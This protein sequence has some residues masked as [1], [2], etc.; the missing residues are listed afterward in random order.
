MKLR[1]TNQWSHT[2]VY[3]LSQKDQDD[4]DMVC[5]GWLIYKDDYAD[6]EDL[7]YATPEIEEM[8]NCLDVDN[9]NP[10]RFAEIYETLEQDNYYVE[11]C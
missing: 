8:V 4:F 2:E 1:F 3:V 9:W 11:V 5:Q 6:P 10:K 7:E